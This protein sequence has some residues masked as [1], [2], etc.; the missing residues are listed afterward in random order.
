MRLF[1]FALFAAIGNAIYAIAMKKASVQNSMMFIG[2]ASFVYVIVLF[3]VHA[4][5]GVDDT[6]LSSLI[7]SDWKWII[8]CGIGLAITYIGF[9]MMYGYYGAT[10]YVYYAVLAIL[11]TTVFV[12]IIMFKEKINIYHVV[13]IVLAIVTV[14]LFSIGNMKAGK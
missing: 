8:L 13:A 12:G 2:L 7:K 5:I 6:K 1:L 4:L 3:L 10:S 9:N 11:T 14:V